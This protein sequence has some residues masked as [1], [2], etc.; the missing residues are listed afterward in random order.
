MSSLLESQI[1]QSIGAKPDQS[2]AEALVQHVKHLNDDQQYSHIVVGTGMGGGAVAR[3][4]IERG[5]KV[6]IIERG[7]A[8]FLTHCLNTSRPH[9][10]HDS[11]EAPGRDNELL[12]NMLPTSWELAPSSSSSSEDPD[13]SACGGKPYYGIGG[14]SLFWSL[15]SPEISKDTAKANFPP[16]VAGSF[17]DN[18]WYDKAA[19][20]LANSPP[21]DTEYA[22][23]AEVT[24][25]DAATLNEAVRDFD[26]DKP[27]AVPQG[28]EFTNGSN[29][30]YFPQGAYSTADWLIDQIWNNKL[31]T[32]VCG[33]EVV[34]FSLDTKT[35]N[36]HKDHNV[37][38]L[39]LRDD[40]GTYCLPVH[41]STKVILCAGAVNTA[42]IA[43][44]SG[45]NGAADFKKTHHRA[46]QGLTDHEV[47][48][49]KYF[50]RIGHDQLGE[51][52][53]EVSCNLKING[54]PALVTV[55]I[56]AEKFYGHGFSTGD[57]HPE[58]RSSDLVNVLNILI[59][60]EAPLNEAGE[61]ILS[62]S[63]Q[64]PVE[65]RNP[66]L[67][68]NRTRLD[69]SQAFN[70]RLRELCKSIRTNFG[71]D[72]ADKPQLAKWGSI[73]HEVGTMRMDRPDY[74]GG[75]HKG[76][77]D[78][79]MKVHKVENLYACDLSVLPFSP[80]ANPS[81]TLTAL[82]MR[83]ADHLDSIE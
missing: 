62:G 38:Y 60:F 30:Y 6:L 18:G 33:V 22:S 68:I 53:V 16:Q 32:V 37:E 40:K 70:D 65:Q 23:T 75:L 17:W 46:G 12:Y 80:T 24:T 69:A 39:I 11:Q 45:K 9:F 44:R 48:M 27:V 1:R 58:P 63:D 19:R 21:G 55:C 50:K 52:A 35:H 2:V 13:P 36:N 79:D 64:M 71:F 73:A 3:M 8:E 29:L 42:A 77:V 72:G 74:D 76:V 66:Q 49:A 31:S 67:R 81:K 83:L 82:A 10:H 41:G 15:E 78:S 59:E 20:L 5:H 57:E 25:A 4:L 47:W 28:A 34:R 26:S 7:H 56:H 43:L 61:V 54:H 14:R 51:Q